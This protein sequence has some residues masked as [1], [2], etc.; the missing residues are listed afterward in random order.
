MSSETAQAHPGLQ[1]CFR[2]TVEANSW[3]S[4]DSRQ[5]SRG[6]EN[7][8]ETVWL[9]GLAEACGRQHGAPSSPRPVWPSS[10]HGSHPL[11]MGWGEALAAAIPGPGAGGRGVWI[12][13]EDLGLSQNYQADPR[14]G[15]KEG[16]PGSAEEL[17]VQWAGEWRWVRR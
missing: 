4:T 8:W 3:P 5:V 16:G 7:S 1:A 2:W 13:K 9:Q 15:G 6:C 10:T 11:P 12:R 17:W 14:K